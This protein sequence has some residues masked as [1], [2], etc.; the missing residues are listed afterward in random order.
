MDKYIKNIIEEKF[1]SKSQQRFF[2]AKAGDKDSSKKERQKWSNLAKEFSDKTDYEKIPDKVESEVDEIVDEKG[3]IARKKI[4]VTRASKGSTHKTTDEVVKTTTGTM[5]NYGLGQTGSK[6]LRFYGEA[7]MSKALGFEKTLGQDADIEDAEEYFEKELG[8]SEPETEERL[9]SYGYDEKLPDDKVRLI[10]NPKKY[11][12][13][14]VESVLSK[15]SSSKD[16]ITKDQTEDVSKEI[17]PIIQRQIKSL[18]NT[19][20]KNNLSIQDVIKLLNKNDE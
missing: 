6:T 17:S 14:Y 7:D 16:L 1:T 9:S 20:V 3:N 12:S 11:I 18:K 8:M 2:F 10:E 15:K 5:G 13:D 4:P 19:L